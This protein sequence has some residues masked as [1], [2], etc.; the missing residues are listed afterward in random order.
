MEM[1]VSSDDKREMVID[2]PDQPVCATAEL[3]DEYHDRCIADNAPEVPTV[4]PTAPANL[5]SNKKQDFSEF[6]EILEVI[7]KVDLLSIVNPVQNYQARIAKHLSSMEE[8]QSKFESHIKK[9]V[10]DQLITM[11]NTLN[12]HLNKIPVNDQ[13]DQYKDLYLDKSNSLKHK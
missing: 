6:S 5:L 12:E 2:S 7:E 1:P 9:V 13:S 8:K 11:D 10:D 4:V 3:V